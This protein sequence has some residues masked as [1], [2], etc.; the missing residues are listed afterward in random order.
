MTDLHAP[1]KLVYDAPVTSVIRVGSPVARRNN[2]AHSNGQ[3]FFFFRVAREHGSF[4]AGR[5]G[6]PKGC[7]GPSPVYQPTRSA[8]SFGSER[9]VSYLKRLSNIS[10]ASLTTPASG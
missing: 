2:R 1:R 4:F 10:T 7:A 9:Q 8:L 6:H 5:V 3:R